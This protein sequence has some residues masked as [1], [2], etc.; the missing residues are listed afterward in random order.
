[1]LD[2]ARCGGPVPA[3]SD[4]PADDLTDLSC[5]QSARRS[6]KRPHDVPDLVPTLS[7]MAGIPSFQ[8][9]DVLDFS[10]AQ[11][12]AAQI[13]G[14]L[15]KC[16]MPALGRRTTPF[17]DDCLLTLHPIVLHLCGSLLGQQFAH[18]PQPGAV[19]RWHRLL[20]RF[21]DGWDDGL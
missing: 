19:R 5:S 4:E 18:Q 17:L 6:P 12:S 20:H 11:A 21:G 1:M 7:R 14:K 3:G 2:A 13:D 8:P 9:K 15:E 10:H 16:R